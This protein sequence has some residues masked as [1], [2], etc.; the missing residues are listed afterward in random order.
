M[1]LKACDLKK[2]LSNE[3]RFDMVGDSLSFLQLFGVCAG[4][5][6]Q[7]E[8]V[9][10][11]LTSRKNVEANLHFSLIAYVLKVKMHIF[12]HLLHDSPIKQCK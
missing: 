7:S 1:C 5:G 2:F 11:A 9:E 10:N 12:N 4:A 3:T 6:A 8:L